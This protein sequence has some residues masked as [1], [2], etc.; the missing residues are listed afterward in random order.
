MSALSIIQANLIQH[1]PPPVTQNSG[2]TS[3]GDPTAGSGGDNPS[4]VNPEL[5]S[6]ITIGDRV[7]AGILTTLVLALLVGT[8]WWMI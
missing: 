6:K 8:C 1:V 7:G 2:G 5:A 4:T 3:K